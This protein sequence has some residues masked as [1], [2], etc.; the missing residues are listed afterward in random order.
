MKRPKHS[1]LIGSTGHQK[2]L[3]QKLLE[4]HGQF[5]TE[6]LGRSRPQMTISVRDLGQKSEIERFCRTFDTTSG[7]IKFVIDDLQDAGPVAGLLATHHSSPSTHWLVTGCDYPLLETETLKQLWSNHTVKTWTTC[8]QNDEGY[9]EPLLAIWSPDAL[10]ELEV[11]TR[12]ARET[13]RR[14]GPSSAIRAFEKD[15]R[16]ANQIPKVVRVQPKN[17]IWI[18]NVN[19]PTDWQEVSSMTHHCHNVQHVSLS[20]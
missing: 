12:I 17:M 10:Q 5:Q 16:H 1:L 4:H 20:P 18:K 15:H 8:F 19:T 13:D 2:S 3:L 6:E 7:D 11:M 14:I 9:H